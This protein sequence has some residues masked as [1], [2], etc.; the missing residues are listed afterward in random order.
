MTEISQ[1]CQSR[2]LYVIEDCAEAH[3]ARYDGHPV[4]SFSDV[5]SF[6]F[7][8]NKIITSG[9]GGMCVTKD[10]DLARRM[11]VLRD[12]GMAPERRYWHEQVGFNYRLTNLQASIGCAQLARMDDFLVARQHVHELYRDAMADIPQVVFPGPMSS[13]CAPVTWFSCALVPADKRQA[14]IEACKAAKID[15]RPFFNSLSAMPAYEKYAG[16]CPVSRSLSLSGVNLPTSSKIDA[17]LARKM[18]SIFRS[19]LG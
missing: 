2:G 3:G 8:A 19:V 10:A 4:G 9:E 13:R 7:F 11:R 14:L 5:A 1:L 6:S 18:A 12:H 17:R 15:L 16:A